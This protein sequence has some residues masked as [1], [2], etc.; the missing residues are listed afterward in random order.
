MTYCDALLRMLVL[1]G[2][3]A[4][5]VGVMYLVC[6]LAEK[7]VKPHTKENGHEE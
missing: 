6:R 1:V 5:P 2:T 3:V 7:G 4:V